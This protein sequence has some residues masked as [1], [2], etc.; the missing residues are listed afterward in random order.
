MNGVP[1]LM[2]D[3][4]GSERLAAF[5]ERTVVA[6]IHTEGVKSHNAPWR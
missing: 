5:P 1:N 4:S 3:L 6:G 2:V